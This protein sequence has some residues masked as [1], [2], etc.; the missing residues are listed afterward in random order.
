[1]TTIQPLEYPQSEEATK[2]AIETLLEDWDSHFSSL[3]KGGLPERFDAIVR[4]GFYPYYFSQNRKILYIG[5]EALGL[6]GC[7]YLEVLAHSYRT[8][9]RVGEKHLNASF[10]HARM[11]HIA[12]GILNREPDWDEIPWA[13]EIG[14]TFGMPGGVSFAFMNLSKVSNESGN[15]ASDWNLINRACSASQT[16]RNFPKEEIEMLA[17]DL[18]IAMNIADKLGPVLGKLEDFFRTDDAEGYV[19][20]LGERQTLLINT[21]HFS[22]FGKRHVEHFYGPICEILNHWD[23]HRASEANTS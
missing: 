18:I 2:Q 9:K 16:H 12:Y 5:R 14:D 15:W 21:W 3:Q 1:M 8:G 6:E 19:V 23:N 20:T 11:L 22:A 7:N 17:P 10:F 13:S 4:D